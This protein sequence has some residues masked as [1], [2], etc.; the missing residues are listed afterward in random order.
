MTDFDQGTLYA[1]DDELIDLYDDESLPVVA[2]QHLAGRSWLVYTDWDLWGDEGQRQR[3]LIERLGDDPELEAL[4]LR[5]LVTLRL[6]PRGRRSTV[7]SQ[8]R[9]PAA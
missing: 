8:R 4:S 6:Q 5:F 3:G 9:R 1:G 7:A 2:E